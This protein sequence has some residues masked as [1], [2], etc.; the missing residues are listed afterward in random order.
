MLK[1]A[2]S[3]RIEVCQKKEQWR[4]TTSPRARCVSGCVAVLVRPGRRLVVSRQKGATLLCISSVHLCSRECL[5][6]ADH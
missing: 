5:S 2:V 1:L 6:C 3:W 4:M